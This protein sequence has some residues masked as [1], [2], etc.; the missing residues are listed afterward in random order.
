M[1]TMMLTLMCHGG[2]ELLLHVPGMAENWSFVMAEIFCFSCGCNFHL[3]CIKH[4]K[5]HS[6]ELGL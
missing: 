5:C 6:A 3:G 1:K 4:G 2:D